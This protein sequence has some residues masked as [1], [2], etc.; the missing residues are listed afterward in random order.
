MLE[1]GSS[2]LFSHS[3]VCSW[4]IFE[5]R[6]NFCFLSH[7]LFYKSNSWN[8]TESEI[9][10]FYIYSMIIIIVAVVVMA[11]QCANDGRSSTQRIN[12]PF[13]LRTFIALRPFVLGV[14]DCECKKNGEWNANWLNAVCL[15]TFGHESKMPKKKNWKRNSLT[16]NVFTL[17]KFKYLLN[18]SFV[19]CVLA[20]E[21]L[22]LSHFTRPTAQARRRRRRTK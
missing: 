6:V 1:S 7:L 13:L 19:D 5:S 4:L 10:I 11:L 9:E 18:Y 22:S 16:R 21:A 14:G 15:C 12:Y 17:L 20:V 3:L 2:L 8:R